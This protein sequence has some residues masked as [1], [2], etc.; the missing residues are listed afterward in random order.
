VLEL[1]DFNALSGMI[2]SIIFFKEEKKRRGGKRMVWVN[3]SL[4]GT[5][6]LLSHVAVVTCTPVPV[7]PLLRILATFPLGRDIPS[8]TNPPLM[9]YSEGSS[10]EIWPPLCSAD[11]STLL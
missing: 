8:E 6:S 11:R 9:A 1:I 3:N 2:S 10:V 4:T 7:S 5:A